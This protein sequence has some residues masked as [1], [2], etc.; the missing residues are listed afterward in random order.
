MGAEALRASRAARTESPAL[1][2]GLRVAPRWQKMF[3]KPIMLFNKICLVNNTHHVCK[4]LVHLV[5]LVH[6]VV[7]S[8]IDL[9]SL[10]QVILHAFPGHHRGAGAGHPVMTIQVHASDLAGESQV[11]S[12]GD[13]L[14]KSPSYR[15]I[16]WI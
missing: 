14:G 7:A 10:C 12:A 2:L 9:A 5:H 1:N 16:I 4:A 8:K 11:E 3:G 15:L 13:M 6:F